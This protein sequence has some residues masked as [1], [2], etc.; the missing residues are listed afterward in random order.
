MRTRRRVAVD[1]SIDAA[2]PASTPCR[3]AAIRLIGLSGFI[4]TTAFRGSV[5]H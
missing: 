2:V 5:W 1:R 3:S 4:V